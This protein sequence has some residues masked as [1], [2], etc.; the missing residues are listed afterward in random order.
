MTVTEDSYLDLHEI[1][2]DPN[3]LK[4]ISA[5]VASQFSTVKCDLVLTAASSGITLATAIALQ[6]RRPVVYA[7]HSKSAGANR[8]LEADLLSH[9]PSEISTLYVPRNQLKKG[10]KILI[11]DDVATSGRTLSGLASLVKS[12]GCSVCGIFVLVSR[13]DGWRQR[14]DSIVGETKVSVLYELKLGMRS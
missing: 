10:D 3:A 9:N 1:T 14:I 12:S 11:V 5:E 8:Y 6:M 2:S 7:T 4:W 13:S